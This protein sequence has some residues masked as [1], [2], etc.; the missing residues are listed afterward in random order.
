MDKDLTILIN[1]ILNKTIITLNELEQ[2]TLSTKRQVTYR[3]DKINAFIRDNGFPILSIGQQKD[4]LIDLKTRE[5]LTE[6]I[7][8]NHF[9]SQYYLNKKERMDYMYM[10]LFVNQ[11]YISLQHF[12]QAL[13]VS[14]STVINDIKDLNEE[15]AEH[16]IQ[17]INNREKGYFLSGNEIEIRSYMMKLIILSLSDE[18]NTVVLDLLIEDLYLDTFHY[19]KLII[20]EL[21][22]KHGIVFVGDR[23]DEFIYI[24]IY[25]K[26]RINNSELFD[27]G[28]QFLPHFDLIQSMKEFAFTRELMQYYKNTS[29]ISE[30]ELNYMSA[31]ILAVSIGNINENTPDSAIISDIVRR[32][33]TRFESLSGNHY[34]DS[35][36]I[37]Q[38]LYSHFRPAYYRLLFK[39]PIFNPL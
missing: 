8:N 1:M 3:I 24:F 37:F 14:R 6:F 33:M 38:Q 18:K 34:Y 27:F 30:M 19:S 17:I 9:D 5:F 28:G 11:G 16:H 25:L 7:R 21:S 2:E 15:L 4:I 36:E 29:T 32:I 22:V 10:M 26:A 31:W 12:V 23:L 13:Q 20:S 35:T 39:L